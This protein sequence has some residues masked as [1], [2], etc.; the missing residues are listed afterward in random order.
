MDL[1]TTRQRRQHG[2]DALSSQRAEHAY[3]KERRRSETRVLATVG[4]AD[5]GDPEAWRRWAQRLLRVANDERLEL[6]AR[7]CPPAGGSDDVEQVDADGGR[8][9]A[10]ALWEALGLGPRRREQRPEAGGDAPPDPAVLAM[11][12]TRLARPASTV[13]CDAPWLAAEGYGPGAKVVALEPR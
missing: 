3:Q 2:P 9:A 11:T 6:P 13:A 7:Q 8:S 10:R 1:R 5:Q 12:A 4:R